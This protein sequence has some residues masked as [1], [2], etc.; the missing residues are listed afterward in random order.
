MDTDIVFLPG[1][2]LL[3]NFNHNIMT[4][5]RRL[6][7]GATFGMLTIIVLM[8][9]SAVLPAT[10]IGTVWLGVSFVAGSLAGIGISFIIKRKTL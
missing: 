3:Y 4:L 10:D 8:T 1:M 2:D 5:V 6:V 7:Y 9:I